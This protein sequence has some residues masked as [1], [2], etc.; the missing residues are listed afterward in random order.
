[1]TTEQTEAAII[2]TLGLN[3][4][5]RH[6]LLCADPTKPKCCDREASLKSWNYLKARL[7]ELKLSERGGIYRTKANCLRICKN[8][9]IAV[10]YPEGTWYRKCTPEVLEELISEHLIGGRVVE[11]HLITQQR[12]D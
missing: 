7:K 5:K 2:E 6:I 12:L 1:M 10:I 8:G 3:A 11:K 9:P 4:V